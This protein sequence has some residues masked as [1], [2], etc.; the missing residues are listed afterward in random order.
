MVK[1]EL[2]F[3]IIIRARRGVAQLAFCVSSFRTQGIH[4]VSIVFLVSGFSSCAYEKGRNKAK[5]IISNFDFIGPPPLL[6][7][8]TQ[9]YQRF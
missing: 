6:E 7:Q 2:F 9:E 3:A 8:V 4:F 5:M 1:T